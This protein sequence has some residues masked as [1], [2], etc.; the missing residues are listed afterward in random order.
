MYQPTDA[1]YAANYI[2]RYCQD[3]PQ[4]EQRAKYHAILTYDLNNRREQLA[5]I[6]RICA[7]GDM[8]RFEYRRMRGD[9]L[10]EI[11]NTRRVA[12]RYVPA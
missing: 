3:L 5:A 8:S 11:A 1:T 6:R 7:N 9:I 2:N 4:S 10:A 12:A